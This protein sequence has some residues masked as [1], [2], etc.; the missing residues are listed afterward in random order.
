MTHLEPS[1]IVGARNLLSGQ[2]GIMI[3][4]IEGDTQIEQV[5]APA[6]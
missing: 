5:N 4:N 3:S 6:Q 1:W 2:A